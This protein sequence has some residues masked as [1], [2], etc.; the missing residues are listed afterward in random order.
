MDRAGRRRLAPRAQARARLAGPT[1]GGTP[2]VIRRAIRAA[3][4]IQFTP[5][6]WGGGHG[7]FSAAG[8]DCSG[9]VSYVLH[10]AGL[11]HTPEDS[12]DLMGYSAPGPGRYITIYANPGHAYMTILHRRYDTSMRGSNGS[13]WSSQMRSSAGYTV[14]HPV[15]L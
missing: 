14:R 13:R 8:Y 7:S 5:Y 1:T 4:R 11:L 3:N 15:G 6:I 9:S 2:E 10:G 12:S